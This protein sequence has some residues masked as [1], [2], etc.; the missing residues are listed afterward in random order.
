MTSFA[1][2]IDVSVVVYLDDILVYSDNPEQTFGTCPGKSSTVYARNP[3][4]Y[5]PSRQV[6]VPLQLL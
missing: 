4:F 5:A 6:R 2:M 1:D 3:P